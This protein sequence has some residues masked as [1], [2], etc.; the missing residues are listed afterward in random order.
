[1]RRTAEVS[2]DLAGDRAFEAADAFGLGLPLCGP[3]SEVIEGGL[4]GSH[5][6]NDDPVEGGVGLPVTVPAEPMPG[7]LATGG[8]DG[9]GTAE[10]GQ[11]C[12]GADALGWHGQIGGRVV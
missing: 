3:P 9:T 11:G 10:L 6:D 8:R 5:A 2:K 7:R 1:M 4:A 12:F